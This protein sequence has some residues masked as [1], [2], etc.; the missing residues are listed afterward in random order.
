M[1]GDLLITE[2]KVKASDADQ[3]LASVCCLKCFCAVPLPSTMVYFRRTQLLFFF[4]KI[5]G[6]V[7]SR[8][9]ASHP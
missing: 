6:P 3:P 9:V 5:L 2:K 4:F 1:L 7:I 8:T